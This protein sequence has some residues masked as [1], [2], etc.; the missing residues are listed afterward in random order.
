MKVRDPEWLTRAQA[1]RLADVS[2]QAVSQAVLEGRLRSKDWLGKVL[3]Y[4]PDVLAY[5]AISHPNRKVR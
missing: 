5:K 2:H 3:V 4:L 1:A